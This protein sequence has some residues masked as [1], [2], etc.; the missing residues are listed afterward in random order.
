MSLVFFDSKLEIPIRELKVFYH[1]TKLQ[2]MPYDSKLEIPIRELKVVLAEEMSRIS[3]L[4][5]KTRNPNKGIERK[6]VFSLLA[7]KHCAMIQN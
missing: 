2:I 7:S 5:F 1:K 3:R 4:G 6:K